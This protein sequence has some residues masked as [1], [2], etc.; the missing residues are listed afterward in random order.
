M[1]LSLIVPCYNEQDN[2]VPMCE[3]IKGA[4]KSGFDYEIIFVNDGSV[5]KTV[6][7]I[8][9][10]QKERN[11]NIKLVNL[12]RNFGKESAI[13][14]GLSESR[15]DYVSIIDADLQQDPKIVSDMV[16]ILDDDCEVDCV[17]AYQETR[18][19]GKLLAF[20]KNC[21]YKLINKMTEINF[22]QGASDFRT[23]RRTMVD[24][25]LQMQEYYRFSK[26]IFSWVGFNTKYIPYEAKERH[27]GKSKWSF[28]KLFK[29]AFEGIISFSTMPLRIATVVGVL[30]SFISSAYMLIVIVQ[31]LFFGISTSG[32]ATIVVLIL[33]LG[34]LQLFALGILGEYIARNYVETK[35]RPIYIAKEI[36]D[37]ENGKNK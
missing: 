24:A 18:H 4:F 14:A 22:K 12:S 2:I 34:G 32:Y 7:T 26:G 3:A 30:T 23:M 1:K 21:F 13:F 35:K 15:G 6:M 11:E 29:Y 33:L 27:S 37:Y 9:T 17:A 28:W 16:K 10:A 31:K 19:E 5:D 36:I 8:K 25:I 20:Y